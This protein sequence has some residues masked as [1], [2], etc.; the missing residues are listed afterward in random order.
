VDDGAGTADK[1]K[2]D[3]AC[4]DGSFDHGLLISFP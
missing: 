2:A 1:S 3:G 4:G